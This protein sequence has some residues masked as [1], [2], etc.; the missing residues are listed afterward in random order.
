MFIKLSNSKKKLAYFTINILCVIKL[1][2][3]TFIYS[4]SQILLFFFTKNAAVFFNLNQSSPGDRR[5][6]ALACIIIRIFNTLFSYF[7]VTVFMFGFKLRRLYI[8]PKSSWKNGYSKTKKTFTF[9]F[10]SFKEIGNR[11]VTKKVFI[12]TF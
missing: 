12:S 3:V 2:I 4:L 9:I 5:G 11:F 6:F 7:C 10:T 8:F 1:L